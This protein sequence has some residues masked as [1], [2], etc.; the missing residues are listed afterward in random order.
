MKTRSKKKPIFIIVVIV[1][2]AVTAAVII[3]SSFNSAQS[4]TLRGQNGKIT[5]NDTTPGMTIKDGASITGS[6]IPEGNVT[7]Y[8]TVHTED[9]RILGAGNVALNDDG[10]FSR[11]LAFDVKDYKGKKGE[12]ELY[13]QGGDGKRIDEIVTG[14]TFE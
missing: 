10:K 7:M 8:Y 11:N 3:V 9:G 6:F 5:L 1:A 2:F 14:V 4:H 13:L 12:L